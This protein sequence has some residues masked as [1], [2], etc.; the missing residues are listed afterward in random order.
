MASGNV[1]S[2]NQSSADALSQSPKH[3]IIA[4]GD[5][6]ALLTKRRS[7]LH[8]LTFSGIHIALDSVLSVYDVVTIMTTNQIKRL[9]K[10][11]IRAGRV[12]RRFYLGPPGD[13]EQEANT[14]ERHSA[15][16]SEAL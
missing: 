5:V 11:L 15:R 6:D 7:H 9:H 3:A 2:S 4:L 12:D 8:A 14:S 1:G 16:P 10:V 13:D